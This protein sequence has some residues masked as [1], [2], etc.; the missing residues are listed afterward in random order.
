M[1]KKK[2]DIKSGVNFK[3]ICDDPK[4][5]V[6]GSSQFDV[7]QGRLG[8]CWLLAAMAAISQ[9]DELMR[10]VLPPNQSFG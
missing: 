8:D 6:E 5:F 9:H 2:Q 10:I 3:D 4:L 1:I 7:V